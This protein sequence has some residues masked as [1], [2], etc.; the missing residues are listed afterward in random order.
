M[1]WAE[2][3]DGTGVAARDLI[4]LSRARKTVVDIAGW[5]SLK[6]KATEVI[7]RTGNKIIEMRTQS[8]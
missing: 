7:E 8:C 4:E 2:A 6:I 3:D 5:I 1:N